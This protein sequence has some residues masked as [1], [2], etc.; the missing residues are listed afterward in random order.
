MSDVLFEIQVAAKLGF[1]KWSDFRRARREGRV[2]PPTRF[3]RKTPIWSRSKLEQWID[4]VDG[5]E[6]SD[7]SSVEL[8]DRLER[9]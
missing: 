4:G 2:P 7:P 5:P 6:A 1:R 8:L 9:V 3:D